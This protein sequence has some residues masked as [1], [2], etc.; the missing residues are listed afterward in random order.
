MAALAQI[1]VSQYQIVNLYSHSLV[2]AHYVEYFAFTF[3]LQ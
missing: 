1:N 2:S 3:V